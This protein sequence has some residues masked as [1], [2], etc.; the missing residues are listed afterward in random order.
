MLAVRIVFGADGRK[1]RH[2][3]VRGADAL[4][5]ASLTYEQA[6]APPTAA[7]DDVPPE[8]DGR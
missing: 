3:F 5:R 2:R 6:Q 7:P 1:R 4:G 8:L